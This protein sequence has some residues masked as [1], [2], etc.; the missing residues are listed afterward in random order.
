MGKA[1]TTLLATKFCR[2]TLRES[3]NFIEETRNSTAA[4]KATVATPSIDTA[5]VTGYSCRR[6]RLKFHYFSSVMHRSKEVNSFWSSQS[7]EKRTDPKMV[8]QK[9]TIWD[10]SEVVFFICVH[11]SVVTKNSV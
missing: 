10:V 11:F 4:D 8:S 9:N 2:S 1:Q 3:D 5:Y 7:F 6:A